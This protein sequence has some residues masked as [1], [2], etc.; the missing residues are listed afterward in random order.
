MVS[1]TVLFKCDFENLSVMSRVALLWNVRP[2]R[3]SLALKRLRL[4]GDCNYPLSALC[5]KGTSVN[6]LWSLHGVT[7]VAWNS[8]PSDSPTFTQCG[9]DWKWLCFRQWLTLKTVSEGTWQIWMFMHCVNYFPRP[10][11]VCSESDEHWEIC[12][13][14]PWWSESTFLRVNQWQYEC[15]WNVSIFISEG[16]SC[17]LKNM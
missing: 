14:C 2:C 17:E 12:I 1:K 5:N 8:G 15:P 7:F 3:R 13:L 6:V 16:L 9:F 11:C 10:K 4:D